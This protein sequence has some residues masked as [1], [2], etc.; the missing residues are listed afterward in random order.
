MIDFKNFS[1]LDWESYFSE[2]P[3]YRHIAGYG[4]Y[5]KEFSEEALRKTEVF[6]RNI[7]GDVLE[8]GGA[9]GE[10]AIHCLRSSAVKSWEIIDLYDSPLKLTHPK[11]QYTFGDAL[12][13]LE[14][15]KPVDCIFSCRFLECLELQDLG[16]LIKEMNRVAAKQY[17]IVTLYKETKYYNAQTME[18]WKGRDFAPGTTIIS[19]Q[20]FLKL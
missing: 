14:H 15:H 2:H 20:E 3:K 4:N 11:L 5:D 17:H 18:W 12:W 9:R 7:K 6:L 19:F 13:N 16:D 10:R 8:L 1:K